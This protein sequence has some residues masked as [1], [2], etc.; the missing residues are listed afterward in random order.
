MLGSRL[1]AEV[2]V[3][4]QGRSGGSSPRAQPGHRLGP[5]LALAMGT[6]VALV[7]AWLVVADHVT[8]HDTNRDVAIYTQVLWNT[9]NGRPYQTTALINNTS[10]LAEHV[11]PVLLPLALPF[12]L[13]PR[14]EW[15]MVLQQAALALAG[16]PVYLLARRRLG[17]T[18]GP[19]LVLACFYLAPALSEVGF[20]DFHPV[21]F[22]AL[23][24]GFGAYW[25]LTDRPKPAALL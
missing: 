22:A 10:H 24:L 7:W 17:G 13:V 12:A 2:A 15:L 23:P 25:A 21:A 14:P 5:T 8:F 9:A 20:Q 11:A 3:A 6:V 1:T 4:A 19:L 18:W 16:A